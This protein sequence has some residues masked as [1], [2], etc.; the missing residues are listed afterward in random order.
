MSCEG[1]ETWFWFNIFVMSWTVWESYHA[2]ETG[3][4][5][6]Y[7]KDTVVASDDQWANYL[8]VN[9]DATKFH[10]KGIEHSYQLTALFKDEIATGNSAYEPSQGT[11]PEDNA[12]PCRIEQD[13]QD[14]QEE[15]DVDTIFHNEE[16]HRECD[17]N[18]ETGG[19]REN[20][21]CMDSDNNFQYDDEFDEMVADALL[22]V[23]V[24][25]STNYHTTYI[26]KE[27]CCIGAIDGTQINVVTLVDQQLAYR[28]RKGDC[29]QNV[30]AAC[31]FDLKFT[32][33]W[34]RWEGSTHDSRILNEA[35]SRPN[36][37]FPKP[38]S[39]KYYVVDV[40]YAN[41]PG[42]LAPYKG[43]AR[44][45]ILKHMAPFP[46]P[47]QRL[48]VITSMALHNYIRQEAIA[49]AEFQRYDDD[50]GYA[51]DN[52]DMYTH[53]TLSESSG[54]VDQQQ[55]MGIIRDGIA[56]SIW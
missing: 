49:D 30:I 37:N 55:E 18:Q 25:V 3:L 50:E 11:L 29:T 16:E 17:N 46:F 45:T 52:D 38:P 54:M 34:A 53:A 41:M 5:W 19:V 31:S 8:Q 39:G 7:E 2:V 9:T 20:D 27:S 4:G 22:G 10:E 47:T 56:N 12:G 48:I 21:A 33:V 15:M 40:G 32:F 13:T 6:D 43:K 36:L 24:C 28:E 23:A 44:W 14:T 35:L 42:Y 26:V 1:R 51:S